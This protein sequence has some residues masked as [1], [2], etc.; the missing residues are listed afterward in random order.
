MSFHDP[1]DGEP[2]ESGQNDKRDAQREVEGWSDEM[3]LP[4]F[5]A[6]ID[7]E[8]WRG[9]VYAQRHMSTPPTIVLKG[10]WWKRYLPRYR[11][12][13][14]AMNALVQYEWDKGMEKQI[15]NM[16]LDQLMLGSHPVYT[17]HL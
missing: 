12:I 13:K 16:I 11:R 10:W 1:H 15:H 8:S 4:P 17:Q 2:D 9:A 7:A 5:K 14:E 6:E 3:T